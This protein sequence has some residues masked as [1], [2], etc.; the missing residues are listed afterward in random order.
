VTTA[1]Q[2]RSVSNTV[3]S[4]WAD[5]DNAF[6][7][8]DL[9]TSTSG[10]DDQNVYSFTANP[11]TLPDEVPIEGI[12]VKVVRGGDGNDY[13]TIELQD[14]TSTWKLKTGTAYSGSCASGAPESLGGATDD[15]GGSWDA[16][17]INSSSFRVRLTYKASAKANLEYV[18]HIEVTIYYTEPD[19]GTLSVDTIPVKGEV[20]VEAE[21]WGT[22]PQS[23]EL[24]IGFY[25]VSFGE[26]PGYATP[27]PIEVE[28]KKDQTTYV[29]ET[30]TESWYCTLHGTITETEENCDKR[31]FDW[32]TAPDTYT[33][34]WIEEG[35]YGIGEFSHQIVG[36]HLEKT[37]YFRAKA[38]N[39]GGWGYGGEKSVSYSE[40]GGFKKIIF[41]TEPPIGGQFNK[42]A[43]DSEP[44]VPNAWNKMKMGI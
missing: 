7:E 42:L 36:L 33:K 2:T 28:V 40:E 20:F 25:T 31:G 26:V 24:E 41:I 39:A 6:S 4:Q 1:S 3:S 29:E 9:C 5:P 19:I 13:Y 11:F 38:H 10:K 32:G 18:D 37:Y 14:K 22:A 21:S 34:E 44:P 23:R 30:Y 43:Y 27:D 12:V 8:N 17:H 16:S 15:W 35:S